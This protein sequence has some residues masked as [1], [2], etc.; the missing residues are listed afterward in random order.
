MFTNTVSSHVPEW[1]NEWMKAIYLSIYGVD[2]KK[3]VDPS[4]QH[5]KIIGIYSKVPKVCV[6]TSD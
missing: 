1:M 2:L 3:V 5:D 4:L 6:F